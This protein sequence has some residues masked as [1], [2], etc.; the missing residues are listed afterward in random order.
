MGIENRF[1]KDT[2]NWGLKEVVPVIIAQSNVESH[3]GDAET[4][5]V[6][7]SAIVVPKGFFR[8]GATFR[9]TLAGSRVGTAGAA[10]LLITIGSTTVI[11][12]ALPSNTGT[13]YVAQFTVSEYTDFAHQNCFGWVTQNAVATAQDY[14]AATVDV[15]QEVTI[16][17]KATLA[18]GS[19]D[20]Y[21][22][23]VMVEYWVW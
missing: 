5:V 23:H 2:P 19:D 14:A 1:N 4:I 21:V 18:N 13:D 6:T 9:F 7:G 20:V 17:A 15:S 3:T 11:S 22:E 12:I 8:P 10:T 16:Q